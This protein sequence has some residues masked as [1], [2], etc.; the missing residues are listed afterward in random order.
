M[1]KTRRL[2][3]AVLVLLAGCASSQT[4]TTAQKEGSTPPDGTPS[5]LEV[6]AAPASGTPGATAIVEPRPEAPDAADVPSSPA[7]AAKFQE[8]NFN[9]NPPATT[10]IRRVSFG[11]EGADFDP[12]IARDGSRMV[13]ASTQHRK[14][15]D[16][17][18]K[19][20]DSRTVTQLTSDPA[21]DAMPEISPDGTQ[22]AFASNRGGNWDIFV[23]PVTGGRPVQIT[24]DEADEIHPSWSS[25]G[26]SLVFN[27]LGNT[28]NRWEMW[29]AAV[30]NSS[31]PN[32]IG[33][34]LFPRWNPVA[35]T[36]SEGADRILYQ[37]GRERGRRSFSIWTVDYKDGQA[38]NPT[39]I[40]A[41]A[42]AALINPAWSADGKWIAYV[43]VPS[44]SW[45]GMGYTSGHLPPVASLWLTSVE[46]DAPVRL[47]S[48]MGVSLSPAWSGTK[49]LFYVGNRGG[50]ENIWAM[51][52]ATTVTNAQAMLPKGGAG[53]AV[54]K[55]PAAGEEMG[56]EHEPAVTN[57][58]ES[59]E[60]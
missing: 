25:D 15:S 43:Q 57:A 16:I 2:I 24:N 22:I 23:M 12:C 38:G 28:S 9:D 5:F 44:D 59:K 39:E 1:L 35:A 47:T 20:V 50:R 51:D 17:Y 46:G 6:A 3:P 18:I 48:G 55:K 41:S 19:R 33:Y 11:E 36:G 4:G 30:T 13:F 49:T 7:N 58:E 32:F 34:G 53:P 45:N 27:R 60:P 37:L 52:V 10:N 54:A 42:E 29:V 14:T 8:G 26:T 56:E 31:S 40:V 21:D